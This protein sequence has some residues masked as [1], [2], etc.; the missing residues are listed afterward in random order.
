M[1]HVVAG[2]SVVQSVM[3]PEVK[4]TEPVAAPGS[5]LAAKAELAPNGTLAG[6]ALAMNVVLATITVSEA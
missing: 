6:V 2:R 4:V 3:P 5:P 1:S